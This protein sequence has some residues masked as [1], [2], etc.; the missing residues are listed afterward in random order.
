M[1]ACSWYADAGLIVYALISIQRVTCSLNIN[2]VR[3]YCT[4]TDQILFKAA[5][6]RTYCFYG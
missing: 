5:V 1:K 4:Y 3:Q 2:D 6:I